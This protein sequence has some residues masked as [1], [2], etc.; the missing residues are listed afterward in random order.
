MRMLLGVLLSFFASLGVPLPASAVAGTSSTDMDRAQALLARAV[1]RYRTV[2]DRA[3]AEFSRQGAFSDDELYVYVL[4][5]SG[6]MR[7]S[8]GSS[9][10][11][12]GRNVAAM[13]DVTGKPFFAE[14]LETAKSRERGTV[15][16]RWLNWTDNTVQRKQTIFQRVS[17]RIIAVGYY[18]PR[19]S[20][21]Q[22]RAFLQ[23]AVAA[24]KG[25]P[26]AALADF[27]KLGGRFVQ[28]DLYVFVI[29][30][31]SGR[32]V[33]HGVMPRLVGTNGASLRDRN[34]KP[35]IREMISIAQAKG[36][37]EVDYVWPNPI[38][39]RPEP[40]HTL[41][42]VVGRHIVAVGYYTK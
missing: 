3:L 6:V 18:L 30:L 23:Q 4:D 38:T 5:T 27:S 22:A 32:F 42:Q 16:Y 21:E 2:G 14:M 41:F 8:G 20:P 35:I 12:V 26:A 39:K 37:G 36:R 28:D 10:S 11:L 31:D 17:D 9:V 13:T 1:E 25:D 34:G 40:K 15:E 7:A 19:S 29:N 33:A 24:M